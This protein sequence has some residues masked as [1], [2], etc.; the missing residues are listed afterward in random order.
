[1]CSSFKEASSNLCD[2]IAA[3]ARRLCTSRIYPGALSAFFACRLVP[4]SKHPGVRP[5]GVGKVVRRIIGKAIIRVVKKDV[6]LSAGP[7]QACSGIPSGGKAAVHAVRETFARAGTEGDLLVDAS[8]AFNSLNR[9][10]AL[11][12][13]RY[14]CPALETV[15]TNCY[16]VPLRLFVAGEE[17]FFPRREP[18]KGTPWVWLCLPCQ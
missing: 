6:M 2:A 18:P 14:V 9:K 13:M 4:L 3:V 15:L 8:H 11:L 17:R 10:V 1:M 16:Q 12:N 5:I 7:L